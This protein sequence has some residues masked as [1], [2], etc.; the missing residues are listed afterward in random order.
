MIS[1]VSSAY[2]KILTN[3][4][5]PCSTEILEPGCIIGI[6]EEIGDL[7]GEVSHIGL[8][9]DSLGDPGLKPKPLDL[10][11]LTTVMQNSY[12]KSFHL[13]TITL[14]LKVLCRQVWNS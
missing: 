7:L 2:F 5:F 8:H 13:H 12:L 9:I 6:K 11:F 14:D 3:Q 10:S 1:K 4:F